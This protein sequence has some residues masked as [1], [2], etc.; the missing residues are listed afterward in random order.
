MAVQALDP[1]RVINGIPR[2]GDLDNYS[3]SFGFQWNRFAA[4][5]LHPH[6]SERLWRETGWSPAELDGLDILEVGSGAGRFSRVIL[7][8]TR[9]NL[10]SVDYST[11][12]DANLRNNGHLAPDRFHLYQASL[13]ELPFPDASFDKVLCLGVLQHTPDFE[14]SVA[15]LVAKAKSGGEVVVDFYPIR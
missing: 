6:S 10:Y 11:A 8:E 14:A 13:Y 15:A 5:Q 1:R 3:E 2:F 12:V 9:A 7:Q 4:T